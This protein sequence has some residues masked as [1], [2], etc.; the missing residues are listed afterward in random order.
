MK[1]YF[2]A[3]VLLAGLSGC[4]QAVLQGPVTGAEVTITDL[5]SGELAASGELTDDF[6]A[7]QARWENF[8]DFSDFTVLGVLGIIPTLEMP[9]QADRWYLVSVSGGFDI[10]SN[11]DLVPDGNSH[12]SERTH[13]RVDEGRA[14]IDWRFHCRSAFRDRVAVGTRTL[15]DDD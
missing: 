5:R 13:S 7:A 6:A 14:T 4:E 1:Q 2:L 8:D 9:L 10:D 12:S 3:M 11:G 15:S